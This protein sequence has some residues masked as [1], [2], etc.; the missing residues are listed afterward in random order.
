VST[1]PPNPKELLHQDTEILTILKDKATLKV[2][3]EP[4]FMIQE[5]DAHSSKSNSET[6]ININT[7]LNIS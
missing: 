5:E 3:S 6:L 4:F 1:L 7:I 2:L